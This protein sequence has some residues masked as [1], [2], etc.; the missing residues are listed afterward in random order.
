ME[1]SSSLP[2]KFLY[3]YSTSA[4]LSSLDTTALQLSRRRVRIPC[5]AARREETA[6]MGAGVRARGT[7][8][9]RRVA[10]TRV[11][12]RAD[13]E[14]PGA[15]QASLRENPTTTPAIVVRVG[16]GQ[17]LEAERVKQAMALNHTTGPTP[18]EQTENGPHDR[19]EVA[20]LTALTVAQAG[21]ERGGE[22]QAGVEQP[23]ARFRTSENA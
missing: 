11:G 14:P 7:A 6:G 2:A 20:A 18:T 4:L 19:E 1:Q 21:A 8:A 3:R 23:R 15:E 9:S 17:D 10:G 13:R 12:L 16:G 22:N 5:L